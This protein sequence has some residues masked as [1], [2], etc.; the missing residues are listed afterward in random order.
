MGAETL[1]YHALTQL[2]LDK[3]LTA[4]GFNCKDSAAVIGNIIAR[5]VSPGS[6]RYT[7]NWLEAHS[8]LGELLGHDF[9][10]TSL[11]RLYT[12]TDKLLKHQDE[13][14]SFLYQREQDLFQ[15]QQTIVLY[16]LTNTFFEGS[17]ND[18]PKANY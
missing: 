16:D 13:I 5:M 15:L 11:T 7:Q 14:E 2:Q 3:K 1:A 18:N 6:E 4:L 12:V 17:T 9:A 8:G 10:T